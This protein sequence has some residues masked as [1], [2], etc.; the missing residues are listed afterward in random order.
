MSLRTYRSR[1]A[2]PSLTSTR[3][4]ACSISSSSAPRSLHRT[5]ALTLDDVIS[6]ADAV[7]GAASSKGGSDLQLWTQGDSNP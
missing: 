2:H 1:R 7:Q 3:P 4:A 5:D 6:S